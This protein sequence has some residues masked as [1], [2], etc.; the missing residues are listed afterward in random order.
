MDLKIE[1]QFRTK[2]ADD[3][4]SPAG[5]VVISTQSGVA[6]LSDISHVLTDA[7]DSSLGM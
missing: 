2:K 6:L 3:Y 4:L 7:G 5:K 1:V